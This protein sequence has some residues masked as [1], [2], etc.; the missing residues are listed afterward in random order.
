MKNYVSEYCRDNFQKELNEIFGI[1]AWRLESP[2]DDI[3]EEQ[4]PTHISIPIYSPTGVRLIGHAE[5]ISEAQVIGDG[6]DRRIHLAATDITVADLR[7]QVDRPIFPLLEGDSCHCG[8][9]ESSSGFYPCD[10][11]G[12]VVE[13]VRGG[14]WD[15]LYVC[16]ECGQIFK[17]VNEEVPAHLRHLMLRR[18]LYEYRDAIGNLSNLYDKCPELNDE[19]DISSIVFISFDEWWQNIQTLL[20]DFDKDQLWNKNVKG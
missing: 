11:N 16:D 4:I 6:A 19:Y 17:G 7:A 3:P 9:S 14:V 20:K 12:M 2:L 18:R 10:S 5:I 13:P 8:N 1:G 15:G